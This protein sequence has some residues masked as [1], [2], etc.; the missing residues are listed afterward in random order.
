MYEVLLA[1]ETWDTADEPEVV[2]E[3]ARLWHNADKIV[4]SRSLEHTA[5]KR[6]RIER[7]FDVEKI[8][9]LK[10]TLE[11]DMGI[12]GPELAA[13]AIKAGLVDEYHF[14]IWPIVVGG[15]KPALPPG[16]KLDLELVSVRRFD[17]GVVHTHYRTKR[18]E[19]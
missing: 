16:V 13:Q 6:T 3:F 15:G 19:D 11:R 12:G 14:F 4:Y 8:R 10:G 1:W 17:N 5:S 9:Q 18:A 7:E 2:Q